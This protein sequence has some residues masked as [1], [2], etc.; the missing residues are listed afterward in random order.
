M[1][2][3][4]DIAIRLKNISKTF[5]IKDKKNNAIRE[6]V[7][8]FFASNTSRE[9]KALKNIDLEIQK[10]EMFGVIGR[11]GSGKST[12]ISILAGGIRPNKGGQI[13]IN[14]KT[15]RLSLGIGFDRELTAR[16]NIYVNGSIM[17][18]SFRKIGKKFKEII[19]FSELHDFVD[20]RLKYFS[21]GMQS[22]L[23]FAIAIHTDADI[24]LMDEFFGGVGD[25]NFKKKSD[26]IFRRAFLDGRTI[27]HVSHSLSTINKY[28]DRAIL[29][30]GGESIIIDSP[31]IVTSK[32][33]ELILK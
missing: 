25:E 1:S 30:D 9:I 29:L 4:N 16:E 12:L 17:G 18:L 2:E 10:G 23:S 32:Y 11:N 6:K 21:S 8:G 5:H 19:D 13:E 31:E 3:N 22:R 24:L 20:T 26:K 15:I 33:K 28:C 27:I 14:G 7:F